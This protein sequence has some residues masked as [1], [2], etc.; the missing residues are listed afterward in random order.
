M[1]ERMTK[2]LS[3][4]SITTGI[5]AAAAAIPA[6]GL[7]IA[8]RGDPVERVMHH[9]RELEN[10]MRELYGTTKV[11]VLRFEPSEGG[12][13]MVAVCPTMTEKQRARYAA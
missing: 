11:A 8:T 9:T 2:L 1:E 3:R 7:A 12:N 13:P 4:R 5:A 10:A 6:V